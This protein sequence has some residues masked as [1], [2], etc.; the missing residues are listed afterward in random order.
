MR[1]AAGIG[2]LILAA[3]LAANAAAMDRR[4]GAR[5]MGMGDAFVALANDL[6]TLNYNPAG[7]GLEKNL[8]F[9]FE[10]ANLYPG[11]DDGTLQ[12]NHL[13]YAQNFYDAGAVGVSWNNRSLAGVYNENEFLLGYAA[14]FGDQ[15]PFWAGV[16]FKVFYLDYTDAFSLNQNP[17]FGTASQ[18]L[19]IG[20]DLGL[21]Y[22]MLPEAKGA[23]GVRVGFAGINLNQPDLGLQA[24]ARQ[25][26]ELRFGAAAVYGEWD[27][28][29]DLVYSEGSA[30]VH[31]GAEKWFNDGRWAVRSGVIAGAGT[32]FT[33][34]AGATYTFDLSSLKTRLN[35][36]F[37]Y[38]FG[39]IL[40]TAGIHRVSLDLGYPL[41]SK[42]ELKRLAEER[43]RQEKLA[44]ED[45]R[46]K[47]FSLF[48]KTRGRLV[49]MEIQPINKAYPA[50]LADFKHELLEASAMMSRLQFTAA[51]DSLDRL[52]TG[53][54]ALEAKYGEET[55]LKRAQD[56]KLAAEQ[57]AK[58][59]RRAQLIQTVK[60][61]LMKKLLL[62]AS[63]R[64]KIKGL[65][66]N[67]DPKFDADLY[68]AEQ[69]INE[70][71]DRIVQSRDI[72]GFLAKLDEAVKKVSDV[73]SRMA[74]EQ[75]PGPR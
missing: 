17:Y 15:T 44:F 38:S 54:S 70:A 64:Q 55:G 60:A 69:K 50:Q 19:R 28:A 27:A 57:Q 71:R 62:F 32:G 4:I 10:Y 34:A 56:Q 23:P 39:G 75:F 67:A 52:N 22:D 31:A 3:G 30:Q 25:P 59:A 29:A 43:K 26:M 8:E 58:D 35:Y 21:L 49:Q 20:V 14:R 16:G 2:I 51:L 36:A 1:S 24:E 37:N 63:T 7:L 68:D 73:E 13:A 47:A 18:A 65:R 12:E 72:R 5:P 48:E 33:L 41:P 74:Q 53:V 66:R 6:N 11:L 61:F 46:R 40:E 9:A 45:N 42:D